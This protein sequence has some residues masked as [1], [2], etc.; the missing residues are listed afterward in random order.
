MLTPPDNPTLIGGHP[1][2]GSSR[3]PMPVILNSPHHHLALRQLPARRAELQALVG[4]T[5]EVS[6]VRVIRPGPP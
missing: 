6:V 5:V 4:G 3:R 1:D 2:R